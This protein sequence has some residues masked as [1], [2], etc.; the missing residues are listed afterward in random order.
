MTK[1]GNNSKPRPFNSRWM[2]KDTAYKDTSVKK[3]P[4]NT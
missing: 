1:R 2:N 3:T 4:T